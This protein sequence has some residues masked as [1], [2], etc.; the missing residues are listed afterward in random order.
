MLYFGS[1]IFGNIIYRPEIKN[2]IKN[3]NKKFNYDENLNLFDAIFDFSL[4]ELELLDLNDFIVLNR[5][6]SDDIQD[7]YDFYWQEDLPIF[8]STDTVLHVWHLLFDKS[9]EYFEQ[10]IFHP[11]L[12]QFSSKTVEKMESLIENNQ[13]LYHALIYTNVAAK[14]INPQF[15]ISESVFS[16]VSL[17]VEI[18]LAELSYMDARNL[19]GEVNLL[20]FLCDYSQFKPRGHYTHSI[21]LK[22]YFRI[23]KWYSKIPF[24]F[25]SDTKT[26]IKTALYLIWS[27]REVNIEVVHEDWSNDLQKIIDITVLEGTGL[28]IM[29]FFD[30]L[31]EVLAGNV[32]KVT[33]YDLD[34]TTKEITQEENWAV[35]DISNQEIEQIIASIIENDSIASSNSLHETQANLDTPWYN[36]SFF[37]FGEALTLDTFALNHLVY[38]YAGLRILPTCLDLPAVSFNSERAL[39]HLDEKLTDNPYYKLAMEETQ[40]EINEI[41][42]EEKQS[43]HWQWV[44]TLRPLSETEPRSNITDPLLPDFMKT[45]A[46]L[47]EKLTTVMGSW[48][49]LK[50]DMIL[51]SKMG[52]TPTIC[53]TPFGYVE[54]YPELYNQLAK[55]INL[56]SGIMDSFEEKLN[57][58]FTI[59]NVDQY[60]NYL[61][62]FCELLEKLSA[63]SY[64]ELQGTE[65]TEK[66]KEFIQDT[67]YIGP[68]SS[69]SSGISGWLGSLLR[70]ITSLNLDKSEPNTRSSL[71]ADIHTDTNTGGTLH[72]ATGYLEHIIAKVPD[73]YGKNSY[74]IG[75]VFSYYDF[76]LPNYLRFCDEDWQSILNLHIDKTD[77]DNYN[78][79][80]FR[81]GQWA[82]SYMISTEIT[83]SLLYEDET[84][85]IVPDW[86]YKQSS[87]WDQY[88]TTILDTNS[89]N[90]S[91]Y[92]SDISYFDAKNT[93]SLLVIEL[94]VGFL[95]FAAFNKICIKRMKIR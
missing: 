60:S 7:M 37:M 78:F 27:S 31:V 20:N 50:H 68:C 80:Y 63:I 59:W 29:S 33:Y 5:L 95:F 57:V 35:N 19:L 10:V 51:Y 83:T 15:N 25:G 22:Q 14:L 94:F 40:I 74:V 45:D 9:L 43:L 69:G 47:D 61:D 90:F 28:E 56:Y 34:L 23:F 72:L 93:T 58:N 77:N 55:T 92:I 52:I 64:H 11:I 18:I 32:N 86:F 87:E 24:F 66:E 71:L 42:N 21:E 36:K 88:N 1:S 91:D 49:Q 46:W 8:I 54:P 73:W 81:R 44:E 62:Y 75:P 79:S 84:E 53:S 41:P 39:Y 65:L 17:L 26:M 89:Y 4:E 67:Y 48:T 3:S 82:S 70:R 30:H 6:A 85:F 76:I 38:P 2:E 12:T 16:E 13:A